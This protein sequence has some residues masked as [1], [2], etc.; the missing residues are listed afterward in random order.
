MNSIE[1]VKNAYMRALEH[2]KAPVT[3]ENYV[4]Y[5]YPVQCP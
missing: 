4:E 1:D 2:V 5:I 3:I